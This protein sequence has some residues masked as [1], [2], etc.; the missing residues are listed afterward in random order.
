M[1][2]VPVIDP[3]SIESLRELN[4]G[5]GDEFLREIIAIYLEDTPHR[6]AELEQSLAAGDRPKFTRAAHSIKGSSANVGAM[7]VRVVAETLEH[8]SQR[9]GLGDVAAL[10]SQLKQEFARAQFE[11]ARIAAPR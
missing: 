5:D 10:I 8:E 9:A 2:D 3:Q 11:L 1:A 4:P 6:V 7:T